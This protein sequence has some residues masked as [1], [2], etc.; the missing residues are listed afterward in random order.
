MRTDIDIFEIG[1]YGKRRPPFHRKPHPA[2]LCTLCAI[3]LSAGSVQYERRLAPVS[4]A[5]VAQ[6][7]GQPLDKALRF[8]DLLPQPTTPRIRPSTRNLTGTSRPWS[9]KSSFRGWAN[10][11]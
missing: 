9:W 11:A 4:W 8:E 3:E 10:G 2:R 5:T 6:W 7:S 1:R